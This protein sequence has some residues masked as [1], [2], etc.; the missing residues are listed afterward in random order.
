MSAPLQQLSRRQVLGVAAAGAAVAAGAGAL[1]YHL[2]GSSTPSAAPGQWTSP[3]SSSRARAAH[4]LRRAGFAYTSQDL[5]A[6]ASLSYSDLVDQLVNQAAQPL[7]DTMDLTSPS[8]VVRSWYAHMATTGAQFPERMTLFWHGLLT[9]SLNE[10]NHLP[11]VY[12]QNVLFRQDG[13]GDLR[14]LLLGVTYDPLM[15]RYLNL[16]DSTA[17]APN[18]N[19]SRELLELFTLGP[20]NYTETDVREGA[21]A[22]SGIRIRLVDS[23]GQP[24]PA[25]AYRGTSPQQRVAAIEQL[26]RQGARFETRMVQREHDNGTKSYL[27]R[28][29]NLGVEDVID[30]ILAQPACAVHIAGKALVHFCSPSPPSTLV[31]GVATQFRASGYDIRT[32]MRA[33][34]TAPEFLQ[35]R[36]YRSLV[37]QPAD[38]MVATMRVL[39]RPQLAGLAV[40]AGA[41]MGQRL[42]DPPN[43]G[44]WPGGG[45]WITSSAWLARINFAAHVLSASQPLP[46]STTAVQDQLDGVLSASTSQVM[47]G[48]SDE[49][50]RWY[51]VLAGPEFH[52]K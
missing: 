40:R 17:A 31:D 15:A 11:L 5:D 1:T 44:G 9:S 50:D 27:G 41:T 52:L 2:A 19:Y 34:F 45:G 26:V 20:G 47:R 21:R 16:E 33:I 7:S 43:V 46:D 51:A 37:R 25:S 10:S 48:T 22:L 28:Q 8:Q 3:L 4:L 18:E 38:Y 42:Y 13:M 23:A 6:A 29:G 30:A 36:S 12:Q 32:L 14:S 24:V 39:G 35:D 49:T